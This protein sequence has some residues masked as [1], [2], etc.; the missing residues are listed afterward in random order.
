LA[1][2]ACVVLAVV[3]TTPEPP[4]PV[5]EHEPDVVDAVPTGPSIESLLAAGRA[6]A[7]RAIRPR[8]VVV[9]DDLGQDAEA[10]RQAASLP[11]E[12]VLAFLPYPPASPSLARDAARLG[13]EILLH[14]PMA[15]QRSAADPG[16][17][18]LVHG[19]A[20]DELRRRLA[21]ALGRVPGAIGVNNHM[22]S[23]LTQDTDAMGR[24]AACSRPA[25][26]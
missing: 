7:P 23:G 13:H 19:L 3:L 6:V 24:R 18:A 5:V 1:F 14:M 25:S 16:P 17:E 22:G 12:I 8:I 11:P 26:G 15:A 10:A 20:P 9:I 21:A 2:V 4:M